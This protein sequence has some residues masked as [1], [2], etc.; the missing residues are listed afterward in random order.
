MHARWSVF[1]TASQPWV[2]RSPA[3]RSPLSNAREKKK[4]TG[5]LSLSLASLQP[6]P[7]SPSPGPS[8]TA[9][10]RGGMGVEERNN[11]KGKAVRTR[12]PSRIACPFFFFLFLL[13]ILI[14]ACAPLRCLCPVSLSCLRALLCFAC[15]VSFPSPSLPPCLCFPS[16]ASRR[17]DP[18]VSGAN[19]HSPFPRRGAPHTP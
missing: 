6:S 3:C 14:S 5:F 19:R 11:T 10:E 2:P 9:T 12:L 16:F 15:S 8:E 13:P 18:S 1:P 4:D 17:V 7:P